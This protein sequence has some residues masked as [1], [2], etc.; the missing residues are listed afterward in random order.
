MKSF[1]FGE[2][3]ELGVVYNSNKVIGIGLGLTPSIHQLDCIRH[4]VV[5]EQLVLLVVLEVDL[6]VNVLMD[7]WQATDLSR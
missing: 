1:A 7:Y 4:S 2:S 3:W 6:A 5:E